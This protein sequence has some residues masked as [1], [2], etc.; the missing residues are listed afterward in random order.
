MIEKHGMI[1]A[2][3]RAVN[4]P[5]ETQGYN[6]LVEMGLENFAFE[7]VIVRYPDQFTTKALQISKERIAQW[8]RS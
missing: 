6:S 2:V 7:T 8:T 5:E 4:R 1:E 3:D